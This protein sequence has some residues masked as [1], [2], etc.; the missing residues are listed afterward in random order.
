VL[1]IMVLFGIWFVALIGEWY[2]LP[3]EIAAES[4]LTS[5][6]KDESVM[7]YSRYFSV[8][9]FGQDLLHP[10][11][12]RFVTAAV[13]HVGFALVFLGAAQLVMK[14]RDL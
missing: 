10:D 5:L 13:I 4:T 7:A 14:K 8:W 1:N 2:R 12:M 9:H 11:W 6:I 3:G